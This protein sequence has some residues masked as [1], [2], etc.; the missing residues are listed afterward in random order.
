MMSAD[1][2][3][4]SA[5]N[6]YSPYT[7]LLTSR[8]LLRA[9]PAMPAAT[10]QAASAYALSS[11]TVPTSAIGENGTPWSP[12][13]ISVSLEVGVHLVRRGAFVFRRALRHQLGRLDDHHL[14]GVAAHRAAHPI[15]VLGVRADLI[16]DRLELAGGDE[17]AG[18]YHL[19]CILERIGHRSRDVDA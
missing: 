4:T 1:A 2:S 17:P 14:L 5:P 19:G 18:R 11:A 3:P 7:A 10:H 9:L 8:R 15:F 12:I 16:G 13:A 6:P